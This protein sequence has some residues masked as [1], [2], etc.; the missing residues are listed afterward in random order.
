MS[1][2]HWSSCRCKCV[3]TPAAPAPGRPELTFRCT[4]ENGSQEPEG[5]SELPKVPLTESIRCIVIGIC[6]DQSREVNL[7]LLAWT[8][9]TQRWLS[10]GCLA[11][12][13]PTHIHQQLCMPAEMSMASHDM[14]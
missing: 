13:A 12:G 2:P 7:A 11:F 5:A 10:A 6:W 3:G 1:C 9:H 14:N 4:P 8:Q